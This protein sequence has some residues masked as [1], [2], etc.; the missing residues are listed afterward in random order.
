MFEFGILLAAL[1]LG[2]VVGL[3]PL[4][5][6]R[7]DLKTVAVGL[8]ATI[9][10]V[11]VLWLLP[12]LRWE[13]IHRLQRLVEDVMGPL[14]RGASTTGIVTLAAAAGIAEEVL[15][16]GLLQEGLTGWI[17]VGG[18]LVV[19][20]VLFGLVHWVTRLYA[21]LAA[22]V[23]CYLGALYLMTGNLAVPILVHALYDV[24]ALVLLRS[25]SGDSL[26]AQ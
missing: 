20:S 7:L 8:A 4:A 18:A 12:R 9:P 5:T 25:A 22:L 26:R 16:R 10:P 6:I 17:G 19:A 21:V 3:D 24:A 15:F 1:T 11:S 2:W 14:F 23:G 13:A